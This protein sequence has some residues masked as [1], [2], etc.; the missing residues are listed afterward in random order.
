MS[1]KP[2]YKNK[3]HR[4]RLRKRFLAKASESYTD[5]ALLEL[6]LTFAIE[7]E[8]VKPLAQELV[9]I[10][11]SLEQVLSA[12]PDELCK[13]KGLG[14]TSITLLKV[15][16][17]IKSGTISTEKNL[18]LTK[19]G[20]ANQLKLFEDPPNAPTPKLSTLSSRPNKPE[21]IKTHP[22]PAGQSKIERQNSSSRGD[23]GP[24]SK[25]KRAVLSSKKKSFDKM[26]IRRKLQVSN[27]YLLEFDQLARVLNFL[28]E[29]RESKRIKRKV[30]KEN[31]G[32]ADR[33]V[34]GLVSMGTAMGLIKPKVQI[35]TPIGLIIATHDIFLENIGSLEWCHYKAAG[36]YQNLIWFEAFNRLL[37]EESAMT[38]EEWQEYF[39]NKLRGQYTDKTIK[40]HVPKEIRF[41]ID[42]YVEQN[43]NKLE[44]LQRSN[45]ERLYR[46]R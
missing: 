40:G 36:S 7:R 12:P 21:E 6:L 11:G 27:N 3:G 9:K 25:I 16:D 37:P 39:Q 13:V 26:S 33:Q 18:S 22:G 32:L 2:E 43:F 20:D 24:K 41:V 1:E 15:V 44:L 46:R 29:Q 5:E 19:G 17:F 45:D 38:Q 28:L 14:Q 34:E 10:F 35:L 8:D 31:T 4:E 23:I 30:L 42:A